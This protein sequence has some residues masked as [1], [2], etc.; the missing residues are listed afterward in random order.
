[1][2]F[3]LAFCSDALKE[4]KK[5]DNNIKPQLRILIIGVRHAK[6]EENMG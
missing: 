2:T 5:L 4:W 3:E 6:S 1:M